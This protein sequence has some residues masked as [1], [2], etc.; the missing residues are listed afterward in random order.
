V[1]LA[2]GA[3]NLATSLVTYTR[4]DARRNNHVRNLIRK[5]Q[6]YAGCDRMIILKCVLEEVGG[7]VC[8]SGLMAGGVCVWI[9][10]D[11][12]RS[13]CVDQD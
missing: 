6:R 1:T 13:V 4:T 8:G 10:T 11:G 3:V 9:R 5:P 2:P 12:R 7:S